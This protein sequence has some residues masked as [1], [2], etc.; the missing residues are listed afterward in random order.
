MN[1][2]RFHLFEKTQVLVAGGGLLAV[3]F[4]WVG[5]AF[6]PADPLGPIAMLPNGNLA[7]LLLAGAMLLVLSVITGALT[8]H[9]RPEG[10]LLTALVA[11]G[12]LA[13]LSEPMDT[14][15]WRYGAPR[16][17]LYGL[18]ILE[19]LLL[20]I[21]VLLAEWVVMLVRALL[22]RAHPA[23]VWTDPLDRLTDDQRK[24]L[25]GSRVHVR[26][27]GDV[28]DGR[29]TRLPLGVRDTLIGTVW[30]LLSRWRNPRESKDARAAEH[31]AAAGVFRRGA[32]CLLLGVVVGVVLVS[33]LMQSDQRGQILFSLFAG[34]ALAATAARHVFPTRTMFVAWLMPIVAAVVFYLLAAL[35]HGAIRPQYEALPIDWIT[36]GCS[37]SLLGF[38]VAGR[39]RESRIFDTLAHEMQTQA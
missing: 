22:G 5:G 20:G 8:T 31:R 38:W 35:T 1:Y 19:V 33:L 6:Q 37:G 36:A 23:W 17:G 29:E 4:F 24:I 32:G 14:L 10:G 18:L 3:V 16:G 2:K 26:W 30:S 28:L 9:S 11:L 13:L 27:D 12:G 34:F 7:K 15:L 25:R 39:M 21:A